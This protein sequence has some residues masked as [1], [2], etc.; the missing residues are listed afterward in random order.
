MRVAAAATELIAR[1]RAV[2]GGDFSALMR[3]IS[4]AWPSVLA[5]RPRR[6]LRVRDAI[7][8][9]AGRRDSRQR[10]CTILEQVD[11][12]PADL[13][14]MGTHGRSGFERL[15]LGSAT[16]L[17]DAGAAVSSL[18]RPGGDRRLDADARRG[19]AAGPASRG[20]RTSGRGA[21]QPSGVR[22][23]CQGQLSGAS[24]RG[25]SRRPA[26]SWCPGN[27]GRGWRPLSR[28]R[29]SCGTAKS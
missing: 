29:A 11:V 14:V 23:G 10:R 26:S 17:F 19:T 24:R 18:A 5:V 9:C 12:M 21:T 3:G 7:D 2:G 28:D 4:G 1:H 27:G 20:S 8:P 15:I 6:G 13:L 16:G 22:C 25:A